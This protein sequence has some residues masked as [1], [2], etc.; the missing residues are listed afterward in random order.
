[1]FDLGASELSGLSTPPRAHEEDQRLRVIADR[2]PRTQHW[3]QEYVQAVVLLE[4]DLSFPGAEGVFEHAL[5][6]GLLAIAAAEHPDLVTRSFMPSASSLAHSL[7]L[8]H[9]VRASDLWAAVQR[10][11]APRHGRGPGGVLT[12]TDLC[13]LEDLDN[14]PVLRGLHSELLDAHWARIE[15]ADRYER[16]RA[17]SYLRLLDED[18][19][20]HRA[21]VAIVALTPLV[22]PGED[23]VWPQECPICD[24][25]AMNHEGGDDFGYGYTGGTCLVCS[26]RRSDDVAYQAGAMAELNRQLEAD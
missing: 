22:E 10:T 26:Y 9:E 7:A 24:H 3:R 6:N 19:I 2:E 5:T 8:V 11:G 21:Q 14:H 15:V 25:E 13:A 23:I 12:R 18:E 20:I 4:Q 16:D 1:M 17:S